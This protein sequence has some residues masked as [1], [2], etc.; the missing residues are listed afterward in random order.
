MGAELTPLRVVTYSVI[1]GFGEEL[2]FRMLIFGG[3][4]AQPSRQL[5]ALWTTLS[6]MLQAAFFAVLHVKGGFPSGV[7]GG[8]ILFVWA[9]FL[10]AL[11]FW[12][13]GVTLVILLHIQIDIVVFG[14][15]LRQK[16]LQQQNVTATDDG[17]AAKPSE[18]CE[19]PKAQDAECTCEISSG[20]VL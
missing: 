15:I 19:A 9:S 14:L 5:P 3:L 17:D 13:G 20:C 18:R 10:G 6:I 11:R 7:S 1:N 8:C 2:E 12:T 4:L 16:L